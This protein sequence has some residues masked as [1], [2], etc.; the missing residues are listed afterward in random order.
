[1]IKIICFHHL[2]AYDKGMKPSVPET[3]TVVR[4]EGGN[5]VIML[6]GGK[7]C[8]GCGAAE[9][10][11]CRAGGTSMFVTADNDIGA[12]VG[13]TVRI[14]LDKRIK[15]KGFSLAY[16]IPL[17]SFITG[18]VA[19]NAAGAYLSI[20]GLDIIMGF[21]L[22]SLASFFCFRTLRKLDKSHRM[23]VTR[24]IADYLFTVER[25]SDEEMRYLKYSGHH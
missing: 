15:R 23:V 6:K 5:A 3:G 21:A 20:S 13:D 25:P 2:L 12:D 11:L 10:G 7:S 22:L 8:K 9:I 4:L 24:V 14:E 18:A 1:M 17:A 16:L 19:G